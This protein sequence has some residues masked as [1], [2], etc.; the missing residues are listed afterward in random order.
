MNKTTNQNSQ[1]SFKKDTDTKT[2]VPLVEKVLTAEEQAALT[3][4]I[5]LQSLK[6]GNKRFINNQITARDYS[7]MVRKSANDQY[8]KAVI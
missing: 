8:P 6:D 4:D 5:V 3:P 7:A 1:N 2:N